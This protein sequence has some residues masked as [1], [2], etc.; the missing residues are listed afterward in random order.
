MLHRLVGALFFMLCVLPL[1]GNPAITADGPGLVR[2]LAWWGAIKS[3]V[4]CWFPGW[5]GRI[6]ERMLSRPSLQRL[7][8]VLAVAVGILFCWA[9]MVVG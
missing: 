5:M 8:G 4:I 9:S 6:G 3:L 1:I 2:L 7:F